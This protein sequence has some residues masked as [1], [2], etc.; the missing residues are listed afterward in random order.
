M[1]HR[2]A[3]AA[4]ANRIDMIVACLKLGA[5]WTDIGAATGLSRQQAHRRFGEHNHTYQR[6]DP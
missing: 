6:K 1:A 3:E 5:S 2:D 4:V